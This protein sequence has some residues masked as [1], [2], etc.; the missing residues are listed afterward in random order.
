MSLAA[1][2]LA[3]CSLA[4]CARPAP[5]A[6]PTLPGPGEGP[7]DLRQPHWDQ[8]CVQDLSRPVALQ[9]REVVDDPVELAVQLAAL[10]PPVERAT[11]APRVNVA[12]SYATSGE[13][14]TVHLA[15]ST[16]DSAL[17][18]AVLQRVLPAV[19]RQPPMA[20]PL[21]LQL[22]VTRATRTPIVRIQPPELCVPHISHE[23]DQPPRLGEGA[24]LWGGLWGYP[25]PGSDERPPLLVSVRLHADPTG[26]VEVEWVRGDAAL[27]PRVRA[28]L[29]GTVVDPALL[30]GEPAPGN[31]VLT[32]RFPDEE[33]APD[34]G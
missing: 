11:D 18:E 31:V 3:A 7:L 14:R 34:G 12:V 27:L 24:R 13:I 26:E 20:R 6:G 28:A 33:G 16:A 25:R 22:S 8:P 1:C 21:F 30:N 10:L 29:A 15:R 17:A 2:A 5:V 32:F 4:A 9:L 23:E 19:R